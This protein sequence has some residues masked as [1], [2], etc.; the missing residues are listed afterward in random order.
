VAYT[1]EQIA[2]IVERRR[3]DRAPVIEAMREIRAVYNTDIVLPLPEMDRNEK[4]FV[5]NL[6]LRAI[7]QTAS[8]ISSV[9]PFL[10]CPPRD[11]TV[12]ARQTATTRSDAI[13]GWWEHSALDIAD[14]QRARWFV[15]YGSAATIIR[16]DTDEG[17][18]VW[19]LRDPL[20][21]YPPPPSG[22]PAKD[23]APA[24]CAFVH[25][26]P[27][28]WLADNYPTAAVKLTNGRDPSSIDPSEMFEVIEWF[29]EDET[30]LI[31]LANQIK[32]PWEPHSPWQ[33][34]ASFVQ[35]GERAENL[36]GQCPVVVPG[37]VTL[38]RPRGQFDAAVGMYHAHARLMSLGMIATERDVFPDMFLMSRQPGETPQFI[39]G[40]FD[41]RTGQ[42]NMVEG[43]P[44][45]VGQPMGQWVTNMLDRIERAEGITGGIPAEF[46]GESST[47]IRTGR[48]GEQVLEAVIN[49]PMAEDQ[50]ILALARKV[51]TRRAQAIAKA[52]F[53]Q[54]EKTLFVFTVDRSVTYTPD[55]DFDSDVTDVSFPIAGTDA[56]NATIATGQMVG[57]RMMSRR[58]AMELSP[59]IR[60]A[61][62]EH[63]QITTEA[64]EDT[65]LA[66]LQAQ[67]QQGALTLP[68]MAR[69]MELVSSDRKELV[70][71]I[72]QA[73]KEAQDRQASSG[74]PGTPTGPV[75]P[76]TPE[77][78]PGLA[79]PGAGQEQPV[80]PPAQPASLR[81]ALAMAMGA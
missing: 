11:Q 31:G 64:L 48:R 73:Q 79:L 37:R 55:R 35:L 36:T 68:D 3:K 72:M 63:D 9:Q 51:E 49:F 27:Y 77:A 53:G 24:N 81:E 47:N 21:A 20:D 45:A 10:R 76:G 66:V 5:A 74:E 13:T 60:D 14:A 12:D 67:A 56:N 40:P 25:R 43:V 78:Q 59:F 4:P 16:P 7:D 65:A 71:A 2:A 61:E 33:S 34:Y 29:D 41:G 38:D 58:H 18:P 54:R 50:R 30:V 28:Y 26:H 1:V 32:N 6:I 80:A 8:R 39:S 69:I 46:G 15:G 57:A 17:V 23:L 22:N 44:Q 42:W 70:A 52:W 62:A 19:E 75:P